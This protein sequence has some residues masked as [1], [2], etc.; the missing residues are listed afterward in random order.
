V[1]NRQEF[2][3]G[4]AEAGSIASISREG[5]TKYLRKY[6]PQIDKEQTRGEQSRGTTP[7]EQKP[8]SEKIM[9]PEAVHLSDILHL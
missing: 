2:G 1:Y 7:E 8:C 4:I 9:S 3:F 5:M 6:D